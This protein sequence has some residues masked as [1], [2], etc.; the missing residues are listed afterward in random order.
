MGDNGRQVELGVHSKSTHPRAQWVAL[1][2]EDDDDQ[3]DLIGAILKESEVRVIACQSA[4][5]AVKVMETV[6]D[7]A[8][9]VLTDVELSGRM[10]GVE[11]ARELGDRWPNTRVVTTSG[12]CD[13][14]RLATLPQRTRH[15]EKPWR[16]LDIIIELER[17][18]AAH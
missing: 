4:E 17:A 7:K 1:V 12:S 9:F 11:L 2:V 13:T 16:A 8:V 15:L 3:R 5:A 10:D 18:I 6:G 14:K